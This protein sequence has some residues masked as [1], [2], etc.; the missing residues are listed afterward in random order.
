[1]TEKNFSVTVSRSMDNMHK[2]EEE[3]GSLIRSNVDFDSDEK[4]QKFLQNMQLVVS[5]LF[6]NAVKFSTSDEVKIDFN[7]SSEYINVVVETGGKGFCLRPH[8]EDKNY[9]NYQKEYFPSYPD[10]IINKEIVIYH[11]LENEIKCFV[12]NVDMI[13]FKHYKIN[14]GEER[15]MDLNEHYGLFLINALCK[16]VYYQQREDG[17]HIFS[18]KKLVNK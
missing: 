13:E 14:T 4:Q 8:T 17:K 9:E 12:K 15:I 3:M 6:S 1:M 16:E 18:I 2:V 5:E 7:I 11:D 10:S